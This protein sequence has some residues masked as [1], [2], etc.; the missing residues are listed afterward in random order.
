MS[1]FSFENNLSVRKPEATSTV[2]LMAFNKINVVFIYLFILNL[3]II[4]LEKHF[5]SSQIFNMNEP[6]ISA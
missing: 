2:R 4:K 5:N 1:N 3:K 6:G